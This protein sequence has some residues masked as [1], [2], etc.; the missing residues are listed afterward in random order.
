MATKPNHCA[1]HIFLYTIQILVI[2]VII[3]VSVFKL[4]SPENDSQFWGVL[5]S[6]SVAYI[7]PAP[8]PK[9]SCDAGSATSITVD[10]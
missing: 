4:F 3:S 8:N 10:E 1:P 7:I 2:C 9:C 6:G 5:L